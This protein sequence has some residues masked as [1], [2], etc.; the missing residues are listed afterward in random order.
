MKVIIPYKNVSTPE[1]KYCLR[2]IE[3]YVDNPEVTVIGDK[4]TWYKGNY[5]AFKEHPL[6]RYKSR[7]IYEKIK[8]Y[9][10]FLFFNDDHFLL[11]PWENAYHY[12]SRIGDMLNGNHISTPYRKTLENTFNLFGNIKNFDIHCP[13]YYKSLDLD[14]LDWDVSDGYCIKSIY[15]HLHG[16]HGTEYPDCKIRNLTYEKEL[17]ALLKD[18]LYFSTGNVMNKP[19]ITILD[20]LYPDKSQWE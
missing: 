10:N 4:P 8:S 16:I 12:S 14:Y 2:G 15:C 5:I 17:R 11:R 7:N 6:I 18:R 20:E 9:K 1:L 13:I 19:M 3:K